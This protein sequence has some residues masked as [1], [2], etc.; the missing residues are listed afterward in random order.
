MRNQSKPATHLYAVILAG[1]RGTRFW[2]SSR[3]RYPKQLMKLWGQ[4]SLLQ[5]TVERLSP[6][7]PPQRV[8]VFTNG[9][10][11]REVVSQLPA[12]PR[13]QIIAEPVQRNT[14]PCA[15][16]AAELI[17]ARDPE[18]VLGVFP[19]D[20]AVLNPALFRKVAAL[21]FQHAR[22]GEIVVLGIRPRW[23]ETGYGYMEFAQ[24]PSISPL[25]A[26]P[27]K[28]FREKPDVSAARRYLRAQRFFWNSGMF[29]WKASVIREALR[30]Y[31]P[32]TAETLATIAH[33][34]ERQEKPGGN[35]LRRLLK[36][37]YPSCQNISVDYAVLEKAPGVVGIP[38]EIGWNDVGSWRAVYDLLPHD[39]AGNV[40]RSEGLLLDSSGLYVDVPGKFVG[41]VGL[42]D[43]VVVETGDA[44]L[45]ATRDR[46]QEVSRLV[47]ELEK[48]GRDDLL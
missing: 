15:G 16:L 48:S 30:R 5:Q 2:P 18:A 31:L 37:L 33:R 32:Q 21:A 38:C 8:W 39:E 25:Q 13:S 35:A 10:L 24:A 42:K 41:V 45:I 26:L 14:A 27:V 20:Q 40:L 46:A 7:I 19:S 9:I 43:L 28:R 6:L 44:L 17:S 22:R 4:A 12:V 29:F 36:E 34:L 1:G 3:R 23:P 47:S 11:S